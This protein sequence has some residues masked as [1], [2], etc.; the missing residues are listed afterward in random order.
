M[1]WV[2]FLACGDAG[3]GFLS[4]AVNVT[5][6]KEKKEQTSPPNPEAVPQLLQKE[7]FT[8]LFKVW[9]S[10]TQNAEPWTGESVVVAIVVKVP[11]F[12]ECSVVVI[13]NTTLR[14]VKL[15]DRFQQPSD[16]LCVSMVTHRQWETLTWY[17]L[18][19]WMG[20]NVQCQDDW[21]QSPSIC[22][23][24]LLIIVTIG[25]CHRKWVGMLDAQQLFVACCGSSVTVQVEDTAR[26]NCAFGH[27]TVL[28]W[29]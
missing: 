19:S 3:W 17:W 18:L 20:L 4:V 1:G 8:W 16:L 24:L 12:H 13:Y 10:L 7:L 29:L 15:L 5:C 2:V 27:T 14:F 9:W 26:P 11:R 21:F 6:S 25:Q 23:I 28:V 22:F